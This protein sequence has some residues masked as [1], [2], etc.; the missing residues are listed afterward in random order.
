VLRE[1]IRVLEPK[2]LGHSRAGS[3]AS[4]R[5]GRRLCRRPGPR[6]GARNGTA[7]RNGATPEAVVT[8]VQWLPDG[9]AAG[10]VAALHHGLER[11]TPLEPGTRPPLRPWPHSFKSCRRIGRRSVSKTGTTADME[12]GATGAG[13]GA[14]AVAVAA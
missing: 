5:N 14:T 12:R 4:Q 13:T 3:M 10:R 7:A 11:G 1:T 9:T 8:R 2:R 6:P